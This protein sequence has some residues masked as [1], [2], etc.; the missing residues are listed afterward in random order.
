[1]SDLNTHKLSSILF[2]VYDMLKGNKRRSVAKIIFKLLFKL[3]GGQ[4]RSASVRRLMARDYSVDVGV[5]SYGECFVPGAFAPSVKVGK[6]VSIA[7]DVRVFTQNHPIDR[8]STHPYFYE[9]GFR[10]IPED[11][12]EPSLCEIGHDVWIGQGAII[13]PGCKTV[14]TGS[15]IGAGSVVTKDVPP[16]AIVTGNPAKI[17]RYRYPESEIETL[18]QS[19]W[20]ERP[21]DEIK[22]Y[23]QE[24]CVAIGDIPKDSEILRKA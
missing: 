12:L 9:Q 18:L 6:F 13:L 2:S 20:W 7:R 1:M 19:E 4:Y 14:G 5:H 21:I 8:I 24:F 16:Y 23:Q 3:E 10:I 11:Q 17:L 22:R 15:I